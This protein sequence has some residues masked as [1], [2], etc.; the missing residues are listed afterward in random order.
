M[1]R[2]KIDEVKQKLI[3][4]KK[5]YGT[6]ITTDAPRWP[7]L[8]A[9]ANLDFVFID[10]EHIAIDRSALS[11]MCQAYRALDIAPLVRIPAPD[12]YQATIALDA[13]S[14]GIVA[15]YI[16]TAEQVQELR[17]AVKLR[18]IKGA[19][20]SKIL[21]GVPGAVELELEHYTRKRNTNAL[22]VNIESV[23]A[24]ESLDEILAV[25]QLDAILIGPHDLSSN[26]GIPEQYDH[27]AFDQAVR[28]ILSKARAAQVGAGIHYIAD[29]IDQEIAWIQEEGANLI[30]HSAD[31][32]AFIKGMRDDLY[33][34]KKALGE[35]A[36]PKG[37]ESILI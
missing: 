18:P 15:P 36:E 27:P 7:K 9:S 12:P 19:K 26:M 34:I 25:P 22:I 29:D 30:L 3:D 31:I 1:N 13:G 2:F 21:D 6:C 33:K 8:V 16:E 4:R 17:G 23:P 24:M 37:G 10:T 14:C 28:T 35:A 11:W 32:I 20:L 5:V